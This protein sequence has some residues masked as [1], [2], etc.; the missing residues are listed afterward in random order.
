M[1][2]RKDAPRAYTTVIRALVEPENPIGLAAL[3]PSL[4]GELK[5]LQGLPLSNAIKEVNDAYEATLPLHGPTVREEAHD[6]V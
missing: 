5:R 6:V 3:R 2:T 1:F 4:L